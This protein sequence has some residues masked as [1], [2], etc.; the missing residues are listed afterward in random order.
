MTPNAPA[1]PLR[2]SE[3]CVGRRKVPGV[4]APQPREHYKLFIQ[5][6]QSLPVSF[7]P[8][9]NHSRPSIEASFRVYLQKKLKHGRRSSSPP[10]NVCNA[11]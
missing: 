8:A 10:R 1:G 6:K 7:P 2:L 11:L 4:A 3:P 9:P 5:S